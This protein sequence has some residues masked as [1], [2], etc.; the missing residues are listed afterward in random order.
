MKK[1]C[2]PQASVGIG[3]GQ[4]P[5]DWRPGGFQLC[6]RSLGSFCG[7]PW[8]KALGDPRGQPPI[9]L[10]VRGGPGLSLGLWWPQL[11]WLHSFIS[12]LLPHLT[13][14]WLPAEVLS[15]LSLSQVH[16]T[17]SGLLAISEYIELISALGA[18]RCRPLCLECSLSI[19]WCCT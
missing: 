9:F 2:L 3:R 10:E 11:S 14:A 15:N 7:W 1:K 4:N 5:A 17:H 8:G 6:G 18:L 12:S 13:M 19:L 16:S